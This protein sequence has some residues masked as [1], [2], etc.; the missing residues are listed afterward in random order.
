MKIKILLHEICEVV[1]V[2]RNSQ[3]NR[4]EEVSFVANCHQRQ[5]DGGLLILEYEI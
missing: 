3:T 1:K 2:I 5:R 4:L